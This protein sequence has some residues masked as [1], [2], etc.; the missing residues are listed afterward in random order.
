[1]NTYDIKQFRNDEARD[2]L[3]TP[4][5]AAGASAGAQ[6]ALERRRRRVGAYVAIALIGWL[7][8]VV[9][10][11]LNDAFASSPGAPPIRIALG[12]TL[13]I[14]LFLTWFR[15]SAAFRRFVRSS[16]LPLLV[17][18][19][20]WRFGG[21]AFIAL[22]MHGIVPGIFAWPAGLGDMAI[23]LTAPWI[24]LR[25]VRRP[26][27]AV[28]R[29]FVWWNLLGILDL[30]VAVSIGALTT[31]LASGAPGEITAAAMG[32]L[33]LV[34]VPTFLV[35]VFIMLHLTALIQV[36]AR[37]RLYEK[38]VP[39]NTRVARDISRGEALIARL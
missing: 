35:P 32:Q 6:E 14:L 11:A 17:T 13:P 8:L 27:F 2:D 15:A 30:V 1:M 3:L 36:R 28:S 25:L 39:A 16:Y 31:T 5:R 29:A 23:G 18:V 9:S 38:F 7:A 37:R 33:P 21:A 12:L 4:E 26:E 19:Q 10:I 22:H 34:L 24:V 20:A